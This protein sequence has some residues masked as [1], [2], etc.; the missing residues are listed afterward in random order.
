MKRTLKF[1]V[2]ILIII[3][4]CSE[5][6]Q[7]MNVIPESQVE[8]ESFQKFIEKK[9][10]ISPELEFLIRDNQTG[11]I[12][13]EKY[14][15]EPFNVN[16]TA[17][18]CPFYLP[19]VNH[20]VDIWPYVFGG[21]VS[22]DINSNLLQPVLQ[23]ILNDFIYNQQPADKL[24]YPDSFIQGSKYDFYSSNVNTPTLTPSEVN[25]YAKEILCQMLGIRD[26]YYTGQC[27]VAPPMDIEN[28]RIYSANVTIIDGTV[29]SGIAIYGDFYLGHEDY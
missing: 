20:D 14:K 11:E 4:S 2:A 13:I 23:Y 24:F 12:L 3:S 21:G 6:E 1:S 19:Q 29:C 28:S 16:K 7:E 8:K 22:G 18:C 5:N 9:L 17:D 26:I 15:D 25:N 27:Y 10:C